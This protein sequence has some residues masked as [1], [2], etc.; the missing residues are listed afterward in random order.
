MAN[1]VSIL[2]KVA[3]NAQVL[4]LTVASQTASSVV[5]SNGSNN[6]TVSYQAASILA[7]MGGVDPTVSPY[8]GIGTA[9]PGQLVLTAAGTAGTVPGVLDGLVAA[10]LFQMLS[11]FANDIILADSTHTQIAYIRGSTDWLGLGQ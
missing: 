6:L 7:P 1:S 11:G 9:N 8:L 4:G 10:Q 3:R 5:I 2:N